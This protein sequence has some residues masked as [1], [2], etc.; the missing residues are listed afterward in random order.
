MFVESDHDL[1]ISI[2]AGERVEE[3][4]GAIEFRIDVDR[5]DGHE[6]KVQPRSGALRARVANQESSGGIEL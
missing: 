1:V 5:G 6:G 3:D 2:F 4:D